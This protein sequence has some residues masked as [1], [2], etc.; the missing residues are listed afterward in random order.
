MS[1][2]YGKSGSDFL[3]FDNIKEKM[4][5]TAVPTILVF[6]FGIIIE[7]LTNVAII[8]E[9]SIALLVYCIVAI[10][11]TVKTI[12]KNFE[13]NDFN[14]KKVLF[15]VMNVFN[16]IIIFGFVFVSIIICVDLFK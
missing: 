14:D 15:M 1:L 9:I 13:N 10:V 12:I 5:L 7:L 4:V 16:C 3:K 2:T 11:L 6:I 8:K